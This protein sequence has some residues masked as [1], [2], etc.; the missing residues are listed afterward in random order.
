MI[1][2]IKPAPPIA[3]FST[4]CVFR[5]NVEEEYRQYLAKTPEEVAELECPMMFIS[6]PSAKDPHWEEKNPGN[7]CTLKI[8]GTASV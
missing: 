5:A 6:F 4:F 2:S 8:K 7:M 3:T 1:D